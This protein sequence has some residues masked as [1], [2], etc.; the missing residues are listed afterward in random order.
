MAKKSS[1]SSQRGKQQKRS[2]TPTS[3]VSADMRRE[4]EDLAN[5]TG[6]P[7]V[8]EDV[9][10]IAQWNGFV[11]GK[12]YRPVKKPVTIRIDADVLA[13]FKSRGRKYQTRINQIL[14]KH[15]LDRLG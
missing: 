10:D 2:R 1:G 7:V 3:E 8:D 6:E 9:P 11:R 5:Q 4:L 13:W 14:R 12:F 15:M